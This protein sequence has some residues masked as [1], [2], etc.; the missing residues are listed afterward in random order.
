MERIPHSEWSDELGS[1]CGDRMEAPGHFP[2]VSN[3]Y[4]IQAAQ[5]LYSYKKTKVLC[6]RN[7]HELSTR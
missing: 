3:L 6:H 7:V 1:T 5:P 2:F 4:A